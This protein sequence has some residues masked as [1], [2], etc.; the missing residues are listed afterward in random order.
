MKKIQLFFTL[1]I[2]VYFAKGKIDGPLEN[3]S[4]K[5]ISEKNIFSNSLLDRIL[6]TKKNGSV[7]I[8]NKIEFAKEVYLFFNYLDVIKKDPYEQIYFLKPLLKT[9]SRINEYLERNPELK[10]KKIFTIM[11]LLKFS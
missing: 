7:P 4:K 9:R 1:T 10:K 5:F 8:Q 11:E 6:K 3:I 2:M